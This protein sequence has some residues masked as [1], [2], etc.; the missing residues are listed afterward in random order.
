M[1]E[2]ACLGLTGSDPAEEAVD[3]GTH[4]G[5]RPHRLFQPLAVCITTASSQVCTFYHGGYTSCRP[6]LTQLATTI[7]MAGNT[8]TGAI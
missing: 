3:R 4:P 2:Q 8:V 5:F 1:I 6:A 7:K